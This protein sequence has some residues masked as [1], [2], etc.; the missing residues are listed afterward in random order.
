MK[1][2]LL[3][4][5]TFLFVA[6]GTM[7]AV[8]AINYDA[9]IKNQKPSVV[10]P[11][12]IKQDSNLSASL[13]KLLSA[14]AIEAD[15]S[16][17]SEDKTTDLSGKV[18]YSNVNSNIKVDLSI[19][20]QLAG[21]DVYASIIYVD[22]NI[23]ADLCGLKFSGTASDYIATVKYLL[24]LVSKGDFNAQLDTSIFTDLLANLNI[25]T[26]PGGN[27][28]VTA[29]LPA[30]GDIVLIA[31]SG[32][33]P[34]SLSAPSIEVL[35]Q[36]YA[37][38]V[39]F[40]QRNHF[41]I[42]VPTNASTYLAVTSIVDFIDPIYNTFTSSSNLFCGTIGYA[43]TSFD[44]ELLLDKSFNMSGTISTAGIKANFSFV[45]NV[46]VVSCLNLT[47]CGTT[48]ELAE[49]VRTQKT[50]LAQIFSLNFVQTIGEILSGKSS[51]LK[52]GT[53]NNRISS[54]S[55][56]VGDIKAQFN[57]TSSVQ[58]VKIVPHANAIT[59]TEAKE[60]LSDVRKL[61]LETL[62]ADINLNL[63]KTTASGK[64]YKDYA[65]FYFSGTI[66]G[67]SVSLTKYGSYYYLNAYGQKLKFSDTET[68]KLFASLFKN[69]EVSEFDLNTL[70]NFAS[71]NLTKLTRKDY[72]QF[73]IVTSVGSATL[74][75]NAGSVKLE[76]LNLLI[77]RQRISGSASVGIADNSSL[78]R[79]F[80]TSGYVDASD[81]LPAVN[82]CLNTIK[83]GGNYVGNLTLKLGD[84]TLTDISIDLTYTVTNGKF[85]F[86]LVLDN[87][88]VG[89]AVSDYNAFTFKSQQAT[90]VYADGY[91][92]VSRIVR[93][94]A[95][96]KTYADLDKVYSLKTISAG[97]IAEMLG[98]KRSLFEYKNNGS[99]VNPNYSNFI[100]S[101][102]RVDN[103]F[104]LLLKTSVLMSKLSDTNI[105]FYATDLI[106][107]LNASLSYGSLINVN[108][109]LTRK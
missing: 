1:K 83:S 101:V 21:Q 108:L 73:E 42:T 31:D 33:F 5:L 100:G 81:L 60:L 10:T 32:F 80:S 56:K 52:F 91:L 28:Q 26:L 20:G 66:A 76:N 27:Q 50:D 34:I 82:P 54:L 3:Y 45:N 69:N 90:I 44:V 87:L 4:F 64:L 95:Y 24:N 16:F 14:S 35:N 96:G 13:D 6:S 58:K 72:K 107:S 63:G 30:I 85:G 94:R 17:E 67:S 97:D 22:S 25:E 37:L 61:N 65:N 109:N 23:Y 12:D 43:G 2:F 77:N 75:V 86:S 55:L 99:T 11:D 39:N 40:A 15:L 88:P 59:L 49:L 84:I 47:F 78:K 74:S 36:K 57:V 93:A 89:L 62:S 29:S 9:Y 105:N 51:L 8:L 92:Y 79:N 7:C 18:L 53:T 46:L 41:A 104:S 106:Y 48:A 68:S 19:S 102:S 70:L 38:N 103:N 98:L 71:S